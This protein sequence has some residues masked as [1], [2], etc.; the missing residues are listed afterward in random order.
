[1]TIAELH[2]KLSPDRPM[3]ASERMEDLLTS[4]VFGTMKYAGW[5]KGF[6]N[7]LLNAEPAPVMPLPPS[8]THYFDKRE[9]ALIKYRFWPMLINKRE[10]DLAM[11]IEFDFGNKLLVVVEAKYL[12]GTSD[13]EIDEKNEETELTGNQLSDQVNG[14]SVMNSEELLQW[15]GASIAKNDSDGD[16]DKIHLF[17]TAHAELPRM[18]YEYSIEKIGDFWPVPSYW[19][20]WGKLAENLLRNVTYDKSGLDALLVDLSDLLKRKGL[21]PFKGFRMPPVELENINPSFW[22]ETYWDIPPKE[23][24]TYQTFW[25]L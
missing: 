7:W 9:I 16:L 22:N 17:V 12:S 15:F 18:D 11:L 1:M 23:K 14:L 19:L 24:L 20:S 25:D 6:L 2:G 8:I 13:F 4:D 21:I 3:G 5:D 10:P